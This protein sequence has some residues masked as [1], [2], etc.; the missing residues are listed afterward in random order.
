MIGC[1]GADHF[2]LLIA[3]VNYCYRHVTWGSMD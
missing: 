2:L 1:R 3:Q